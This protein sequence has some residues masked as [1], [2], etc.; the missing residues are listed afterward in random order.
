MAT[1]HTGTGD[2]KHKVVSEKEWLEA[3]KELLKKEKEF[4]D[5][6]D[7]ISKLRR[8]LPWVK[9]EKDYVFD[10]PNGKEK[11]SELF[12][13]RSQLIIYHFMLAPDWEEGCASCSYVSDHFDGALVHLAHRDTT[14]AV[15]SHAPI[16][17][18][19][20][21][22][23]RM[24]WN[25]KWLSAFNNDFNFDYHVSFTD[26]ELAKGKVYYNYEMTEFPI[27]EGP[28]I[29]V[30]Y[31]DDT[32]GDIYHT[33]SSYAR[34][35][36]ILLGTYNL[37][38]LTPKGRDEDGLAFSMAWLRYH[39]R[40]DDSYKVDPKTGYQQPKSSECCHQEHHS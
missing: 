31:K 1:L 17:K 36:D 2:K 24:G 32:T 34:G 16:E 38:D 6:R 25:F 39:D 4:T 28:G 22:K 29:S 3:R 33:Y 9:V 13:G 30:F 23:K 40:Y 10:G 20:A 8:E 15:V 7:Q 35:L 37:L 21:F 5:Q 18:I 26:E 14:L 12:D 11:L 27:K 19:Q